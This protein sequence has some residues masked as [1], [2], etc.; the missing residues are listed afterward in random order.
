M[1]G[2]AVGSLFLDIN[3]YAEE[4]GWFTI[5]ELK[6]TDAI[7]EHTYVRA[8]LLTHTRFAVDERV[9]T[10]VYK[11]VSED[12]DRVAYISI[13][14]WH[15]KEAKKTRFLISMQCGKVEE[16]VVLFYEGTP[17]G[18]CKFQH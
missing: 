1:T 10:F 6:M 11:M 8:D 4:D 16:S 5:L 7:M 15:M 9:R 2:Q 12:I 18:R 17:P 13:C 14:P 3:L